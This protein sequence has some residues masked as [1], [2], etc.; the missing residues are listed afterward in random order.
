MKMNLTAWGFVLVAGVICWSNAGRAASNIPDGT[1]HNLSKAAVMD[2]TILAV[3]EDYY[4][5]TRMNPVTMFK[6]A[7]DEVVRT[8]AEMK[9][10]YVEEAGVEKTAVVEVLDQKLNISMA[11]V[12]SPWGVSKAFHRIFTFLVKNLPRNEKVDYRAIEYAAVNGL[13]ATLDPH[14]SAMTPDVWE[15]LRM[16][17]RGAFEGVGI[18]ITTD[19]REPCSGELT[20]VEVFDGTPAQKAGLKVGDKIIRI[21]GDSTVNITTSEA[22]DQLRGEPGTKVKVGLLRKDGTQKTVH[23]TRQRIPIDSVK[24][25]MLDDKVGFIE[26]M[27]F[28][29]GSAGEMRT[30]LDELHE[31]KM[32]GL[33]LDLRSNPGGLLDAAIQIADMFIPSGTL[34]TT[35]GRTKADRDVT[36]ANAEDTEPAY[37]IV[38]LID[39]YT[40]SAAE[41]LSGALRNHGRALL[42]GEPTFGKGSVQNIISLPDDGA[43]R[44]TIQQYLIP[45]DISIQAVGV[46]PDISFLPS[47]VDKKEMIISRRERAFSEASL[48]SHLIRATN[49]ER[50]DR[51]GALEMPYFVSAKQRKV[52]LE[53]FKKC[54]TDNPERKSYRNKYEVEFARKLISAAKGVTTVELLVTA[55]DMVDRMA[56]S[57]QKNVAFA[58]KKLGVD[59]NTPATTDAAHLEEMVPTDS[60]EATATV[61]SRAVAGKDLK[62]TVSVKNKGN[63][64]VHQLRAKTTSDNPYLTGIDL[65]FGKLPPGK[66]K[67]W[68][69]TVSL[70]PVIRSR[71]DPV[72]V[73]FFGAEGQVPAPVNVDVTVEG[74]AEPE[75]VYDW[76]LEDLGNGNGYMEP[77]EQFV[78]HMKV[79]NRGEGPTFKTEANLSSRPGLDVESGRFVMNPL[80]PGKSGSGTFQIQVPAAQEDG[81]QTRDAVELSL[82]FD[83]W[84]PLKVPSLVTLQRQTFTL[85][86]S[87]PMPSMEKADGTVTVGATLDSENAVV[88]STPSK[89]GMSLG[90]ARP[91]ASFAVDGTMNG[92]FRVQLAEKRFGWVS[93]SNVIPGG[94]GGGSFEPKLTQLPIVQ[95]EGKRSLVVKEEKVTVTG[96]VSHPEGLR[97]ILVFVDGKKVQYEQ[98]KRAMTKQQF[99]FVVPIETGANNVSVMAR[100]DNHSVASSNIFVRRTE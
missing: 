72:E 32:K 18:R 67:K 29:Q 77:G 94:K 71:V 63:K 86:V 62:L 52:D 80:K 75:L 87:K 21:E 56:A 47:V 22:A 2:R 74:R 16:S 82:T 10:S 54:Y 1:T 84:V 55:Q 42:I 89:K 4:D 81:S 76:F 3:M 69:A 58:L 99:A 20:V 27:A 45:G 11:G 85:P 36:N 70:P 19:Y 59:W 26:L 30:A 50:G 78:M 98:V 79:T 91:G 7:L 61:A 51:P 41:I 64:T 73:A 38:V 93:T 13:L 100:H 24:W 31:Q 68:T 48:D 9:V 83:E 25:K 97:D 44:M 43:M 28:Q 46:A 90:I 92:F 6:G 96:T 53:M 60:L 57:E 14:T 37:P 15:E 12:Q 5:S 23:I 40:A 8:V 49:I 35:A 33:I 17:T 34:V 65:V 39:G 95:I 66:T 88:Y